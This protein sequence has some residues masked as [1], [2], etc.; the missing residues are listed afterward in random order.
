MCFVSWAGRS[1]GGMAMSEEEERLRRDGE[2]RH[3]AE[4]S[5]GR[6]RRDCDCCLAQGPDLDLV[7]LSP[8]LSLS[9]P[10]AVSTPP[11]TAAPPPSWRRAPPSCT[12]PAHEG[13]SQPSQPR[14]H[15]QQGERARERCTHPEGKDTPAPSPSRLA[16]PARHLHPQLCKFLQAPPRNQHAPFAANR[17]AFVVIYRLLRYHH[18]NRR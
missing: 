4:G 9:I 11:P 16:A 18:P 6:L 17:R 8:S 2:M 5:Y 1:A 3:E 15:R 13:V 14:P 10:R 7:W 12:A